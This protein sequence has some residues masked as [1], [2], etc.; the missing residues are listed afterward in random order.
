[1]K[2]SF[3]SYIQDRFGKAQFDPPEIREARKAYIEGRINKIKEI[4]GDRERKFKL[5]TIRQTDCD[6]SLYLRQ[7]YTYPDSEIGNIE[8]WSRKRSYQCREIKSAIEG[9]KE[10]CLEKDFGDED[11]ELD[12]YFFTALHI[13][14][15][16]NINDP[17]LQ[18]H[19]D[20]FMRRIEVLYKELKGHTDY[21]NQVCLFSVQLHKPD[22]GS[23]IYRISRIF[24]A[25]FD[26]E[27]D[28]GSCRAHLNQLHDEIRK[29]FSELDAIRTME[30]NLFKA[31]GMA[32][33]AELNQIF[34]NPSLAPADKISFML[35]RLKMLL[36]NHV[37]QHF[38]GAQYDENAIDI[39]YVALTY[40]QSETKENHLTPLFQIYPHCYR[41]SYPL[42][43]YR[44]AHQDFPSMVKYLLR[45][46]FQVNIGQ[47]DGYEL[48]MG[49]SAVDN[50]KSDLGQ[51]AI[52]IDSNFIEKI[53]K[54]VDTE[55]DQY[56]VANKIFQNHH[57][58]LFVRRPVSNGHGVG[59]ANDSLAGHYHHRIGQISEKLWNK[60]NLDV[61]TKHD[62][63]TDV[64]T[65][66]MMAFVIEGHKL[67]IN[68]GSKK[69]CK[70]LPR[71][72]LAIESKYY[73]AF[74][75]SERKT[76]REVV[77]FISTLVRSIFHENSLLNYRRKLSDAYKKYVPTGYS[78]AT[79]AGYKQELMARLLLASMAIDVK[80]ARIILESIEC[81]S[82]ASKPLRDFFSPRHI[83]IFKK[84]FQEVLDNTEIDD[85]DV[86]S[87]KIVN[88]RIFS[89]LYNAT[90]YISRRDVHDEYISL[91]VQELEVFIG[92][93]EA[94]PN[95]FA[96][97]GYAPSIAEAFGDR[98]EKTTPSFGLMTP[99]FSGSHLY[100][101][102]VKGEIQQVAK[103]SSLRDLE[104]ELKKYREF[105]RYRLL[106]AA[107]TPSNGMAFD[108]TGDFGRGTYSIMPSSLPSDYSHRTY[109]VLISDLVSAFSGADAKDQINQSQT[110]E[111]L[112]NHV[113]K[114]L[115]SERR[116]DLKVSSSKICISLKNL[117]SKSLTL[118][119][120]VDVPQKVGLPQPIA[121]IVV[122]TLRLKP[123]DKVRAHYEELIKGNKASPLSYLKSNF[124]LECIDIDSMIAP[125]DLPI[126]I[127][128]PDHEQYKNYIVHGDLNARNVIWAAAIDHY[129]LIDFEH[130]TYGIWGSDQLRLIVNLLVDLPS[131]LTRDYLF[132]EDS[133][134]H[135]DKLFREISLGV[136]WLLRS[137][138]TIV[139][140]NHVSDA[141]L[142]PI[143]NA[144]L[145]TIAVRSKLGL[146]DE[147]KSL[148]AYI[149][150]LTILKEL[151]YS[152][153]SV[154]MVL[155]RYAP[156]SD[157]IKHLNINITENIII[158]SDLFAALVS[159]YGYGN[160][161]TSSTDLQNSKIMLVEKSAI[162]RYMIALRLSIGLTRGTGSST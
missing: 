69:L 62:N 147:Q 11:K 125:Y 101:A 54:E 89:R 122:D 154:K 126:V 91:A 45:H 63:D 94:M 55:H 160:N 102:I 52:S 161:T 60:L 15:T 66:S 56:D 109:G 16:V 129:V 145:K 40:E 135:R 120:K 37:K 79:D 139:S 121:K 64:F 80:I 29:L 157:F 153:L 149:L 12:S 138:T 42:A 59:A 30:S 36:D 22:D 103:L 26:F 57:D 85:E 71:A 81:Y 44:I 143:L 113:F 90:A 28:V 76:M 23:D 72:V 162:A 83:K 141:K 34:L 130:T 114:V 158:N 108:S 105:V 2:D 106:L 87:S 32:F 152:I 107:R 100:M 6:D 13:L 86:K 48:V 148:Q 128:N 5:V 25:Y 9:I 47:P 58:Q 133:N 1:M 24:A 8:E 144:V 75:Y 18:L 88:D 43:A 51:S 53:F 73:D 17:E 155:K 65:N 74:T 50:F 67:G 159:L 27:E 111:T 137:F 77:I 97:A 112:I 95:N 127:D 140:A 146:S 96:W 118:W 156:H 132:S 131:E 104:K 150:S 4:L 119:R 98:S 151:E 7:V 35:E 41:K 61:K 46:Y 10:D 49:K 78:N 21:S 82:T 110:V 93:I 116:S 38:I 14:G 3:I 70:Q 134:L 31:Q 142:I 92:L 68:V 20:S 123:S 39:Y 136:D 117:F 115:M 124:Y 33:V 84:Y 99:G 19:N